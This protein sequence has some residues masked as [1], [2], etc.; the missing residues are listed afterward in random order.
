MPAYESQISMME[1]LTM[2]TVQS[3]IICERCGFRESIYEFDCR[4][5]EWWVLCPSCGYSEQC[6]HVSRLSNGRVE[7]SVLTYTYPAG[8]YSAVD[9]DT[10]IA[11]V[12][13]LFETEIEDAAARMRADIASGMLS[14]ESYVTRY[15]SDSGEAAALVGQIPTEVQPDDGLGQV[16]TES[17]PDDEL[18]F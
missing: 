12:G 5:S 10:K 3:T 14:P 16:P 2:S 8:A 9:S 18:L 13:G 4:S 7:K 11:Q 15:C 1:D 17:Q 6:K